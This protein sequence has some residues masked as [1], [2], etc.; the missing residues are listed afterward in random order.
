[1]QE[2]IKLRGVICCAVGR[3]IVGLHRLRLHRGG[4]HGDGFR[5]LLGG[6]SFRLR[7]LGHRLG[8]GCAHACRLGGRL[9]GRSLAELPDVVRADVER[10]TAIQMQYLSSQGGVAAI[11]DIGAP[12]MTLGKFSYSGGDADSAGGMESPL[13]PDLLAYVCAYLRG[14]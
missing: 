7:G 4:G 12:N 14:E 2:V 13:L 1:M 8:R 10:A 11:N 3:G 6:R 9:R 5:G